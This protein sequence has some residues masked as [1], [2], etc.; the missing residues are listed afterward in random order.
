[1]K[2]STE[3]KRTVLE[4][5]SIQLILPSGK[6]AVMRPGIGDDAILATKMCDGQGELYT[7]A[8]ITILTTIDGEKKTME[9]YRK[10]PLSD[11][12]KLMAETSADFM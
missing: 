9:Y 8:M 12:N 1:M 6:I 3:E 11:Y 4:D 5:G 7:V 10:G 2:N